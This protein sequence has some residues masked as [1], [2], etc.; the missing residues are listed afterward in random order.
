MLS[1]YSGA[2]CGSALKP[3]AIVTHRSKDCEL[4]KFNNH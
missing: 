3:M 2:E 4:Y 1:L